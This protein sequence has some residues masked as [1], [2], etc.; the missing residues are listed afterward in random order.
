MSNSN[1][2]QMLYQLPEYR[3]LDTKRK[4]LI[5]FH[6]L[7][8]VAF[9]RACTMLTLNKSRESKREDVK[10]CL[11]AFSE[12][13]DP[14]G[15]TETLALIH[16]LEGYF[17]HAEIDRDNFQ[18]YVDFWNDKGPFPTPLSAGLQPKDP[19]WQAAASQLPG[20][21]SATQGAHE[22]R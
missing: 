17:T 9:S 3:V 15:R 10:A 2:R 16:W 22:T 1:K 7:D 8:R 11:K 12:K 6:L 5:S 20:W 19:N 18:R 4:K 21:Y 14:G 13:Q